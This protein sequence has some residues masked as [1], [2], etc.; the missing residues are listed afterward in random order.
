MSKNII[1]YLFFK[2]VICDRYFQYEYKQK[3]TDISYLLGLYLYKKD[4]VNIK[5]YFRID[6][7]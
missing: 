5:P 6:K 7:F 3:S 2:K 1:I 4:K